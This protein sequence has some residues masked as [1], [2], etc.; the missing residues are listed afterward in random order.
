MTK[1]IQWHVQ[2]HAVFKKGSIHLK[3]TTA[4]KPMLHLGHCVGY[5]MRCNFAV[6]KNVVQNVEHSFVTYAYLS[7]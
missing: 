7:S 2:L 1:P 3:P 4:A 6:S 5:P